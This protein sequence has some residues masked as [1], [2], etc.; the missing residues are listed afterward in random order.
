MVFLYFVDKPKKNAS[1]TDITDDEQKYYA[2]V[3]TYGD[4]YTD[5]KLHTISVIVFYSSNKLQSML[6]DYA[7]TDMGCLDYYS[8]AVPRAKIMRGNGIT[9]FILHVAQCIIF[10]QTKFVTATLIAKDRLK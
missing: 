8:D 7:V 6:V 10:N 9:T 2:F 1:R 5:F 4:G 3:P